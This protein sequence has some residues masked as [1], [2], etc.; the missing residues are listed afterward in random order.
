MKKFFLY[1]IIILCSLELIL[2]IIGFGYSLINRPNLKI[3]KG[4]FKI[5][6]LGE[7]TTLGMA[8]SQN[9]NYPMQLQEILN[10][11]IPKRKFQVFWGMDIGVNS[12]KILLNLPKYIKKYEPNL[13]IA[14]IGGNNWFNLDQSNILLFSRHKLVSRHTFLIITFLHKFRV[15]KLAKLLYYKAINY[16]A[17]SGWLPY[18]ESNIPQHH[19]ELYDNILKYDLIEIVKICKKNG[20]KIVISG[21]PIDDC[22]LVH[23]EVARKYGIPF[24]DNWYSFEKLKNKGILSEYLIKDDW[25]PNEKGY[26]IIANNI[27]SVLEKNNFLH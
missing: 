1:F 10:K 21:Y 2:R 7:S 9:M 27:C 8:V 22:R 19:R 6:C 18:D 11:E 15:F 14:M 24:V 26:T 23:M 16:K 25:H 12:S 17:E 13:V 4:T 20:I 5:F 3:D